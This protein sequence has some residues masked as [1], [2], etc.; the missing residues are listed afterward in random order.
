MRG[1]TWELRG[2]TWHRV[3]I[4]PSPTPRIG[5]A[6]TYDP[7]RGHVVLFGGVDGN[8]SYLGDTWT[9]D[10]TNWIRHA[11]SPSPSPRYDSA[12]AFDVTRGVCVLFGGFGN[13]G[14][15]AD[16]WEF[17]GTRWTARTTTT[18]PAARRE[19]SLVFDGMSGRV[20]LFGGADAVGTYQSDTWQYAAANPALVNSYQIGC[21]GTTATPRL[22]ATANGLPWLGGRL[23]LQLTHSGGSGPAVLI[24]GLSRSTWATSRLPLDLW[25]FGMPGCRLATSIDASATLAMTQGLASFGL[26]VPNQTALLGASVYVQGLAVDPGANASGAVLSNAVEAVFGAR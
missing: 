8:S 10:G 12:M 9:Y 16:A 5:V 24:Y 14:V 23:E 20:L 2:G 7:M 22:E 6:M 19:H 25:A 18:R 15:V 13:G 26:L 4:S 1:D 11:L 17:D 3:A 21:A